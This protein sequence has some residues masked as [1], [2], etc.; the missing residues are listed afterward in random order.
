MYGE[1]RTPDAHVQRPQDSAAC[2]GEWTINRLAR[3]I[4]FN[5]AP[6]GK[7]LPDKETMH[8]SV[9]ARVL[10]NPDQPNWIA[11]ESNIT[12]QGHVP[13]LPGFQW[14]H[15]VVLYSIASWQRPIG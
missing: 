13:Y 3:H 1:G 6:N 15:H 7:I 4:S 2:L 14:W 11:Q 5:T 10:R 12:L 8:A 9:R